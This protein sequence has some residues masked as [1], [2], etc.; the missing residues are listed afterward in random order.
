M[1]RILIAYLSLS[2]NTEEV[3]ELIAAQCEKIADV[4]LYR[5]GYGSPPPT[6]SDY[7]IVMIGTFTWR[8]G[9]VPSQIDSF[10]DRVQHNH[11][12]VFGTGDTQFG[13][14]DL[15]CRAADI[16]ADEFNSAHPVLKIEQS[17]RGAQEKKVIEWTKGVLRN[18]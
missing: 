18:E 8:R 10:I 9:E 15:F 2:G 5:I 3:A 4:D 1:V 14:D 6:F 13:G 16:L 17:P 11:I 7:D 12:A